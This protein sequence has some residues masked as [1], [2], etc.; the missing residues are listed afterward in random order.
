MMIVFWNIYL[1][2]VIYVFYLILYQHCEENRAVIRL[3]LC[4]RKLKPKDIRLFDY[5]YTASK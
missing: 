2:R 5:G 4:I 1:C 3:I